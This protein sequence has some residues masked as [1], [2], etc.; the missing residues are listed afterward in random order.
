MSTHPRT[1][2]VLAAVVVAVA[3]SARSASA[4]PVG[5]IAADTVTQPAPQVDSSRVHEYHGEYSTDFESSWFHACD[6]PRGD[7]FWW[8]TLSEDARLQRDS[9]MKRLPVRPTH[10]LAVRWRA[11][12]SPRMR[13]G[14]GHMGRGSR[15]TLVTEILSLRAIADGEEGACG[16]GSRAGG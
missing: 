5:A 14:A 16:V 15:Y 13:I 1:C 7:D 2:F 6:A 10:G 8:V 11:T 9:L 3:A 12:V 4:S